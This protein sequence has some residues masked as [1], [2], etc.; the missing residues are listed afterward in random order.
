MALSGTR[1]CDLPHYTG[2]STFR[3]CSRGE[4]W[5]SKDPFS[6]D[7]GQRAMVSTS[8]DASVDGD[9]LTEHSRISLIWSCH[10]IYAASSP[11]FLPG[12]LSRHPQTS[13]SRSNLTRQRRP[14]GGPGFSPVD[15]EGSSIRLSFCLCRVVRG[16]SLLR[17]KSHFPHQP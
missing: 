11:T 6:R 9:V 14:R 10:W 13:V 4:R 17:H 3:C 2:A 8:Q 16:S 15:M 7:H 5:C 12:C 1:T